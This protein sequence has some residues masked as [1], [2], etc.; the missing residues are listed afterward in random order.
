[1]SALKEL[2][3]YRD[4]DC[5][6]WTRCVTMGVCVMCHS[7]SNSKSQG[8]FKATKMVIRTTPP[9]TILLSTLPFFPFA[10]VV[11]FY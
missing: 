1:M 7:N 11:Y 5:C 9:F 8:C 4:N 6:T 3:I 2:G 10:S